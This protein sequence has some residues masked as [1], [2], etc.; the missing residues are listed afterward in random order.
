M[1]ENGFSKVTALGGCLFLLSFLFV[2]YFVDEETATLAGSSSEEIDLSDEIKQEEETA[3]NSGP[4]KRTLALQENEE[5][6]KLSCSPTNAAVN[7]NVDG[8]KRKKDTFSFLKVAS[9]SSVVDLLLIRFILAF[10]MLMFRSNFT[11]ML[12]FRYGTT[13]KTN[14]YILSYNGLLSACSGFLVGPL[15]SRVYHNNDAKMLLHFSVL[16]TVSILCITFAPGISTLV[17]FIAPLSLSSA[18]SRVC[19]TNLTFK[20]S[21]EDEKGLL[22]GI[23]NSL[24]SIARMISPALGGLAQELSIY[25]PGSV[26]VA[27]AG[28]GVLIM[29][30]YPQDRPRVSRKDKRK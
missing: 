8:E 21:Q 10:S 28:V 18:V 24:S 16:M 20:R 25:G 22:Q 13:P 2:W 26:G 5:E 11:T 23:G 4:R 17:L 1:Q 19:T 7:G 3:P 6:T 15:M 9:A 29:V 30:V 27:L 14:G 12:E